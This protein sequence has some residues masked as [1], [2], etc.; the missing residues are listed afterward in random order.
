MKVKK[1]DTIRVYGQVVEVVEIDKDDMLRLKHPIVVPFMEY[2]RDCI[3]P[4][5]VQGI[6]EY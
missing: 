2:T 1:G 5:E 3:Y 6:L 4:N